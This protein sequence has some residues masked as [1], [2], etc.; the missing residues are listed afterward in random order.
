MDL[1]LITVPYGEDILIKDLEENYNIRG[2]KL[3]LGRVLVNVKDEIGASLLVYKL[4]SITRGLL[5]LDYGKIEKK[6]NEIS[7]EDLK[8][9]AKRLDFSFLK[10][11][12]FAVRSER[13]GEHN[14][15]RM[16]IMREIGEVVL[17]NSGAK[18]DLENPDFIIRFDLIFN[19]YYIGIDLVGEKSL[20]K[21][22]YK[23]FQHHA[24]INGVLAY[25]MV[26]FSEWRDK[27]PFLD[28][29]C[30]SGTIPIEAAHKA[31]KMPGAYFRKDLMMFKMF[32]LEEF[33]KEIN[34]NIEFDKEL[35]IYGFDKMKKS[36]E[37]AKENAK[38]ALVGDKIEFKTLSL[39]WLD[40]KFKENEIGNIVTNPPYGIRIGSPKKVEPIYKEL[41]YQ[42][43]YIAK[44]IT[45]I[46]TLE[47]FVYKYAK[48]NKLK[49]QKKK[50]I[51]NQK[52]MTKLFNLSK[53]F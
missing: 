3:S 13:V 38:N 50:P 12:K 41:L 18:V 26:V 15:N 53:E 24:A 31:I 35:I 36:I 8:N 17:R 44:K 30:G 25:L 23:V 5:L 40:W 19:H 29:M 1:L 7:L 34:E 11:K 37:G 22:N 10:G 21:R 47:D 45:L 33:I 20:M 28:P 2:K 32:K 9:L 39:E 42:G 43:S 27:E 51:F 16:D 52:L 49:I 4:R 46:T 48:E 6:D 14:F